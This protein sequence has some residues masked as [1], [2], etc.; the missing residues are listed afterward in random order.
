MVHFSPLKLPSKT[1][2]KRNAGQIYRTQT[3]QQD[4][5]IDEA[6]FLRHVWSMWARQ[7]CDFGRMSAY[8]VPIS[9]S[10]TTAEPSVTRAGP[11]RTARPHPS[12]TRIGMIFFSADQALND[13]H[14]LAKL[15]CY[16]E[17][18]ISI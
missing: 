1:S 2:S 10:A 3:C 15:G 16:P 12:A 6:S 9:L 13:K 4:T 7:F 18:I 5:M 8:S 11:I 17:V 14:F